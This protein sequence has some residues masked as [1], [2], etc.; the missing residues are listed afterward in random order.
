MIDF[1]S[2][3]AFFWVAQL[4]SF[5]A[6]S[7]RLN[8]T[9]PAVSI[10]IAK[11]EADLGVKLFDRGPRTF[12]LTPK[13]RELLDY[14]DR[15]LR[16]RVEMIE[17][18]AT[19]SAISGVVRLGVAETIVHTW[20]ARFVERVHATYPKV[21]LD[22]EVDVSPSLQQ[23]L[24]ERRI[25]LALL[26]GPVADPTVSNLDLCRYSLSF[27]AKAGTELGPE[28]VPLERLIEAPIITYPKTTLPYIHLRQLLSRRGLPAPRIYS[29]SSL[30]TIIRMTL[31]GIGIS[32]I[33]PVVIQDELKRGELRLVSAEPVLQDLSFTCSLAITPDPVPLHDLAQLACEVARSEARPGRPAQ[34]D[35]AA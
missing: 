32:V 24:V 30:S 22:I 29:N 21:T 35:K 2:V 10:R 17:A 34:S 8:M 28:P 20:L 1:R 6:A 26:L 25:D 27:V 19:R 15:L 13:G 11:L 9:Q 7:K 4:Q 23:A 14:A 33:P 18:V 31:D 3:E 12:A 16:L 5:G